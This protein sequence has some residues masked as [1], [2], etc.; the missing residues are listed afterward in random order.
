[1]TTRPNA[2]KTQSFEFVEFSSRE[3]QKLKDLFTAMGFTACGKH[4]TQSVTLYKQ[5]NIHFFVN[6]EPSGFS[7]EFTN[8]HGPCACSMGFRVENVDHAMTMLLE[9]GAKE[10]NCSGR[11]LPPSIRAIQGIGGAH[12]YVVDAAGAAE[13]YAAFPKVD[14]SAGVGL[15]ELDH[16]THNVYQGQMDVWAG[17]YEKLFDFY[18]I[19]Y[20]DIKG[21]RTGLH[22]RAMSAPCG[23]IR[24]PLNESADEVSQIAEYLEEY[25]GE[26]IQHIALTTKDIYDSVEKLRRAGIPFLTVPQTYYQDVPKRLPFQKEDLPRMERNHILIDGDKK[27]ETFLLQIF[28][29]NAVG[30]IFFEIIQRHGHKGFG[31][32][33]FQALFDAMERDQIERGVLKA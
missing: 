13:L 19:R 29:K 4:E 16:L 12:L 18:E 15:L 2:I 10:I 24:I 6:E 26:G 23:N 20:F 7:A 5:G 31:E 14:V 17:Y 1:M 3:P 22:S 27:D 11:F 32:G 33:N 9:R 8:A 30:P 21:Q 25:K 28:T